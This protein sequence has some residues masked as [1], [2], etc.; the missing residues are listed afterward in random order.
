MSAAAAVRSDVR[1][2]SGSDGRFPRDVMEYAGV[3]AADAPTE[4]RSF[5]IWYERQGGCY[6]LPDCSESGERRSAADTLRAFAKAFPQLGR[7]HRITWRFGPHDRLQLDAGS[8]HDLAVTMGASGQ[9]GSALAFHVAVPG[10][11]R[12]ITVVRTETDRRPGEFG[13]MAAHRGGESRLQAEADTLGR[14]GRMLGIQGQ[15]PCSGHG[16]LPEQAL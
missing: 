11:Y 15:V 12:K 16:R 6:L 13:K 1:S 9:G 5:A 2:V 14:L 4:G 10:A 8:L 7:P 3:R